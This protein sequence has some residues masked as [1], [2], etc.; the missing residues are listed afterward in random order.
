M[1]VLYWGGATFF[2]WVL[3]IQLML[4]IELATVFGCSSPETRTLLDNPT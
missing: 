3:Y 2:S 4:T 1:A